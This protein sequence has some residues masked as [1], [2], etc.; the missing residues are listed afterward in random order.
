MQ[1]CNHK[2]E[3][4]K[5]TESHQT[6]AIRSTNSTKLDCEQSNL[7]TDNWNKV[8]QRKHHLAI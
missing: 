5:S 1:T 4:S 7:S 2:E 3:A 8:V 6:L